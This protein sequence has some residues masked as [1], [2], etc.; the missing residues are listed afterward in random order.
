M[1]N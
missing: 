1:H